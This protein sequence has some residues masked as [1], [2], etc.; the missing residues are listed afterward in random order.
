MRL[1]DGGSLRF[2][3]ESA[4]KV[5]ASTRYGSKSR[6]FAG[7]KKVHVEDGDN[8]FTELTVVHFNRVQQ[9]CI[10]ALA[11]E[12][13]IFC[14]TP[15]VFHVWHSIPH[16]KTGES[17][18]TASTALFQLTERPSRWRIFCAHE[19]EGFFRYGVGCVF[20]NSRTSTF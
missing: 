1:L 4:H 7:I 17:S 11:I 16:E 2:A 10:S 20:R 6:F 19:N 12:L 9:N 18:A 13:T 3:S 5:A 8:R 15:K 14:Q